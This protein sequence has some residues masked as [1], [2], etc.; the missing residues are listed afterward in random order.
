MAAPVSPSTRPWS[1]AWHAGSIR[2]ASE[3]K[4]VAAGSGGRASRLADR[5][6]VAVRGTAQI[7]PAQGM[8]EAGSS[9]S[10][11]ICPG[12]SRGPSPTGLWGRHVDPFFVHSSAIARIDRVD[13]YRPVNLPA[14]LPGRR[15]RGTGPPPPPAPPPPYRPES[16]LARLS[17]WW[18]PGRARRR[19]GPSR[20]ACWL[21]IV[22]AVL[23]GLGG[24][25]RLAA[26]ISGLA[27]LAVAASPSRS[28]ARG[29]RLPGP[30][31]QAA[32]R[33]RQRP[34]PGCVVGVALHALAP[35]PD[36]R[37]PMDPG[38]PLPAALEPARLQ[39]R[40]PRRRSSSSAS[41]APGSCQSTRSLWPAVRFTGW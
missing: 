18:R 39:P 21:A 23:G 11:S 26:R 41:P 28:P 35:A 15:H 10:I 3:F 5:S 17:A 40:V 9:C 14:H 24:F 37:L 12:P 34:R 30:L 1:I 13:G 38:R 32:V 22:L 29:D 20:P 19:G 27:L 16:A 31:P 7:L 36:L 33:R 8:A 25:V 2:R 4:Y 6:L